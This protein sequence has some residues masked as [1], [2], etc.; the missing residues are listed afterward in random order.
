MS[1]SEGTAVAATSVII[2]AYNSSASL[3][4]T[5]D[6][7]VGQTVPPHEII[8]ID[9]GSTDDTAEIARSYGDRVTVLS[10]ANQGQGAA[11][12]TGL[13]QATGRHIA[14]LDA[15]DYWDLTFLERME[16]FLDTH[17]QAVAVSCAFKAI[18]NTDDY[19]GPA[20]YAELKQQYPDGFLLDDFFGF[21]ADT[22]HIRTGTTL[23]RRNT[24]EA[25]GR[26]N[27]AL[28]N[29]QDLE[30]WALVATEGTW[31]LLPE[32]LWYGTSAVFAKQAGWRKR[33]K[34]RRKNTPTVAAWQARILPRLSDTDLPAFRRVR[35]R[36]ALGYA[37]NHVLGGDLWAA[38]D[39]MRDFGVDIPK[40]S[41]TARVLHLGH[42]L[43]P[44][45]WLGARFVLRAYDRL[46]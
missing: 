23:I 28:R 44:V 40:G 17:P 22:D 37:L 13:A 16:H 2:P 5:L 6:S 1:N 19:Y 33:Y 39:I 12:N 41:M 8:V 26:Q 4:T 45:G 35:G 42:R 11:R 34:V 30:F 7:V 15:D 38:R 36:V 18:R 29:S 27:P 24:V 9:D 25:V 32:V 14:L 46:K 3:R 43:G 10:Q 21:W 20:H 31:G